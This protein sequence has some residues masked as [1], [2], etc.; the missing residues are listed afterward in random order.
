[1]SLAARQ[2]NQNEGIAGDRRQIRW[3]SMHMELRW[4]LIGRRKLLSSGSGSTLD[5]SSAGIVFDAGRPLPF[6]SKMEVSIAWPVLLDD[7]LPLQLVMRGRILH[8]HGNNVAL[9]I[10]QHE[11]RTVQALQSQSHAGRG[12]QREAAGQVLRIQDNGRAFDPEDPPVSKS[13]TPKTNL[14]FGR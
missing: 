7:T 13:L 14:R 8:C 6:G 4:T 5:L 3:F 9:R 1:M 12:G 11:F 10:F 2:Q